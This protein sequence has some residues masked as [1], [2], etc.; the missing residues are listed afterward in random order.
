MYVSARCRLA[1]A[2]GSFCRASPMSLA[3]F[4]WTYVGFVFIICLVLLLLFQLLFDHVCDW[5]LFLSGKNV[6]GRW[7]IAQEASKVEVM[8]S[9]TQLDDEKKLEVHFAEKSLRLL[10][11]W[12]LMVYFLLDQSAFFG[13]RLFKWTAQ[14][15]ISTLTFFD[16]SQPVHEGSYNHDQPKP[17]CKH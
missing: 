10:A 14:V 7:L 5:S 15:E 1:I 12:R 2:V 9:L 3:V 17:P 11:F 8:V 13:V 16:S 4:S 6:P